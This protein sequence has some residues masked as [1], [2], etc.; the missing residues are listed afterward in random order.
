MLDNQIQALTTIIKDK[1]LQGYTGDSFWDL[2]QAVV[3]QDPFSGIGAA[4]NI[5]ELILHMPTVL[6]WDKMKKF[7]LGTFHSYEDQIKMAQKFN[8]DNIDYTTFVKRQIH[9][10]NALDDDMKVDYFAA[11]TRSF[12]ITGLDRELYFKLC[13]FLS[14]CTLEELLFMEQCPYDF[15][16]ANTAMISSLFQYGLFTSDIDHETG[17]THYILSDFAK[18]LKQ[19]S[20]NYEDGLRGQPRFCS[21]GQLASLNLPETATKA[22]VDALFNEVW[23]DESKTTTDK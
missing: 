13:K 18:A 7:L 19:H 22:E 17:E 15:K 1:D 9:L 11:L 20:L 23:H 6:F 10:I 3:M 5:K 2:I 8:D 4:K 14:T 21:Y 12:L 16:S